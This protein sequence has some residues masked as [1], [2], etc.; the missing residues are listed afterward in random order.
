MSQQVPVSGSNKD[1]LELNLPIIHQDDQAYEPLNFSRVEEGKL[2]NGQQTQPPMFTTPE[3]T[4]TEPC[5]NILFDDD[6]FT[7]DQDTV[8]SVSSEKYQVPLKSI[9]KIFCPA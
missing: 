2:L 3:V 6:N 9:Q 1:V 4:L 8:Q 5:R 7:Y